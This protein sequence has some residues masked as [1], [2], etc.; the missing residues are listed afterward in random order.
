MDE[1]LPIQLAIRQQNYAAID[2]L[3]AQ[4]MLNINI[5]TAHGLAINM[6][7]Q[8]GDAAVI[9]KILMKD[10]NF[11]AKDHLGRTVYD[12]LCADADPNIA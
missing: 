9:E 12:V 7:V 4:P 3:V 6:A 10:V 8:T 11:S 2:L 1:W 5:C